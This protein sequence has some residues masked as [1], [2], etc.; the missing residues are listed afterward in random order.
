MT[1][2]D[3]VFVNGGRFTEDTLYLATFINGEETDDGKVKFSYEVKDTN[4]GTSIIN[5]SISNNSYNL[6]K[7]LRNHTHFDEHD[8]DMT[9]LKAANHLVLIGQYEGYAFIQNVFPTGVNAL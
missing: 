5:R 2:K 3:K 6:K 9:K 7:W 1:W 8:P 4:G